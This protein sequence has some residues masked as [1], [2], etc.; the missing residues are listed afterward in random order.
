M[1]GFLQGFVDNE[2]N[3]NAEGSCSNTCADYKNTKQYGC[4]KDTP[5]AATLNKPNKINHCKGTVRECEFIE[6]DLEICPS[7]IKY[8]HKKNVHKLL[9]F[10]QVTVYFL[11]R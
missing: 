7:V 1:N 11:Y 9:L 2:I 8:F 6:S 10:N 5:C 3:L 4:H